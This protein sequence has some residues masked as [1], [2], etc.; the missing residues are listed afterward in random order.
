[1]R[2]V[3]ISIICHS[4]GQFSVGKNMGGFNGST[5]FASLEEANAS[6]RKLQAE[7]GGP[8]NAEIKVHDHRRKAEQGDRAAL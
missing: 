8:G 1:M 2:M 6:A 5:V 3:V 7:A 4:N